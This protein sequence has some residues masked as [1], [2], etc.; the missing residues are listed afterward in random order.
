MLS[1]A[2]SSHGSTA[3]PPCRPRSYRGTMRT[4]TPRRGWRARRHYHR[5]MDQR[6]MWGLFGPEVLERITVVSPHFDDAVMGAGYLLLRHPATTV[7]T[8]L[9]G[10]PPAY[11]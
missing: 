6:E 10:R 8:V 5:P 4:E 9:A 3:P 2:T 11:P 1:R 7:I